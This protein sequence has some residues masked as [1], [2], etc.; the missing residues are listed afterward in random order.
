MWWIVQIDV[1]EIGKAYAYRPSDADGFNQFF[2]MDG[3]PVAEAIEAYTTLQVDAPK[4]K[5]WTDPTP[6]EPVAFWE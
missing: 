5:W 2:H 3:A 4:P 1:P 6:P